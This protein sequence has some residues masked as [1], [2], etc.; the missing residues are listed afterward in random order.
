[1]TSEESAEPENRESEEQTET[2]VMETSEESA[3]SDGRGSEEQPETEVIEISEESP[4]P[5]D[6]KPEGEREAEDTEMP[7]KSTDTVE[8]ESG[9]MQKTETS[10]E[11]SETAAQESEVQLDSDVSN[12]YLEM[13]NQETQSETET[14]SEETELQ[15]LEES[16]TEEPEEKKYTISL[17]END[18]VDVV[19][20]SDT[21]LAGE[22]VLLT[23]S[24]HEDTTVESVIASTVSGEKIS[25][26]TT[27]EASTETP[28][29]FSFEMPEEDVILGVESE[30]V[31]LSEIQLFA[32]GDAKLTSVYFSRDG[33][34][35][36]AA[37][38]SNGGGEDRK[39]VVY[40]YSDGTE[41]R[42]AAYC[43]QNRVHG[44][45]EEGYYNSELYALDSSSGKELRLRKALFYCYG[46]PG[47][48]KTFSGVN[49]KK[50]M[51]TYGLG[52]DSDYYYATHNLVS[53]I[54][55]GKY[56]SYLNTKGISLMKELYGYIDDLPDPSVCMLSKEKLLATQGETGSTRYKAVP[57][58]TATLKLP[59]GITFVNDESGKKHTGTVTM[60]GGTIFHL[61][62]D[63]D[64]K[65]AGKYTLSTKYGTSYEAYAI[66]VSGV[67]DIGFAA[68]S[69]EEGTLS[70]TVSKG[71]AAD[72]VYVVK[73]SDDPDNWIEK[74][75]NYYSLEDTEFTFYEDKEKTEKLGTVSVGSNGKSGKLKIELG[76]AE[77]KTVYYQETARG[78]GHTIDPELHSITL[79]RNHTEPYEI[80]RENHIVYVVI[81]SA[82]VKQDAAGNPLS[83]AQIRVHYY[84]DDSS[85]E[86]EVANWVFETGTDGKMIVS[87]ARKISGPTIAT[88]NG[89][90]VFPRGYYA[91]E[92]IK[93]PAGYCI[94]EDNNVIYKKAT[95]PSKV[96][97]LYTNPK[98]TVSS[99]KMI[100]SNDW[101]IRVRKVSSEP[102]I[103]EDNDRYSLK[104]AVFGFYDE[105]GKLLGTETTDEEGYTPYL[106]LDSID[107]TAESVKI[108]V[109][110]EKA[111]KGFIINST[112]KTVT[113]TKTSPARSVK[114]ADEPIYTEMKIRKVTTEEVPGI[115]LANC[116]FGV[117][118]DESCSN[119]YLVQKM[120]TLS[121]G[122]TD[123]VELDYGTYWL[124][125]LSC[126]EI[127]KINTEIKKLT[128]TKARKEGEIVE[129]QFPNV[130]VTY[131]VSVKKVSAN[132]SVTNGNSCYSFMGA[133]FHVAKDAAM[134]QVI[135]TLEVKDESGMTDSV[136]LTKGTYYIQEAAPAPKGYRINTEIRKVT[137]AK[138]GEV[139]EIADEPFTG[140]TERLLLKKTDYSTNASLA[141]A[142]F[143]VKFY[144]GET[145]TGTPLRTWKLRTVKDEK[146]G[147]YV[148][149][150]S[151]E[152]FISGDDFFTDKDGKIILPLGC[153]TFR[154]TAAPDGFRVNDS[155]LTNYITLEENAAETTGTGRVLYNT[156]TIKEE[157][158]FG[159]VIIDK[160][161]ADSGQQTDGDAVL[162]GAVFSITSLNDFSVSIADQ[163]GRAYDKND[164]VAVIT[165][166][167]DGIAR[168]GAVLQAG[169]YR[170][171]EKTAP[172]GY[173]LSSQTIEF[174]IKNHGEI[175]D[176]TGTPVIDE[177]IRGGFMLQKV[178][179]DTGKD[180][181]QGDADLAGAQ[182]T[183][184]NRSA[185]SVKVNGRV[186]KPGDTV[187]TLTT[188]EKG[189]AQTEKKVLPYGTYEVRETVPP[190]GYQIDMAVKTVTIT[191]E[192]QY[193]K[194]SYTYQ[195]PVIRGGIRVNKYDIEVNAVGGRQGDAA[196]AGAVFTII[197]ESSHPVIVDGKE[198]ANGEV[199][200]ALTTGED[201]TAAT[202]ASALPYGTYRITETKAPYGYLLS[203]ENIAK[204]VQIRENG[205][206]MTDEVKEDVI[207]GGI[208]IAKW[209]QELNRGKAA[210]GAATLAGAEFTLT[211]GSG[212]SVY[213]DADQDGVREVYAPG[214]VIA[215]LAADEDGEVETA[216]D[217]LPC[218]TYHVKE[219]KAPT[220]YTRKGEHLEWDFSIGGKEDDNRKIC[221]RTTADTAV[222]NVPV[223]F[224]IDLF[225]FKDSLTS[226][227][228]T[229]RM[230]PLEG[231]QF[232]I[233]NVNEQ[234]VIVRGKTYQPGEVVMTVTTDEHGFASTNEKNAGNCES[235]ALPYGK[236][237]ISEVNCPEGLTPVKDFIV[238]GTEEGGV[239][240]GK[241]YK[242]LYLN[243]IP[244]E[245]RIRIRKTDAQTGS[246]IP[247][248]ATF[249]ILD[250]EK[251]VMDFLVTYPTTYHVTEFTTNAEGNIETPTK[252]PYGTYYLRE[253]DPPYDREGLRNG[254]VLGED[255]QFQVN[256]NNAWEDVIEVTYTDLPA[257]G[258]ITVTKTDGKTG[259]KISGAVFA[260]FADEDI[261]T[262]DGTLRHK[263]GEQIDVFTV[264]E[265]GEGTSRPL[266]LGAYH[267]QEIKAPKGYCLDTGIYPF[268]LTYDEAHKE[269]EIRHEVL[270][271]SIPNR[272]TVLKLQKKDVDGLVLDGITFEL[273]RIGGESDSGIVNEKA[274]SGGQYVT[275]EGGSIRIPY[276]VSGIYV[277][278]E[279]ETLPGYVLDT[280]LRY[281]AVD[282]N[283]FIYESDQDGKNLDEDNARSDTL[284]L[285][286]INDY[287]KC[288][289]SK[290][291]VTGEKEI[292]GAELEIYDAEGT[293]MYSWTSVEEPHRINKIPAGDYT[294]VEKCAPEGYVMANSVAFTVTE[295]GEVQKTVMI[296]KQILVHKTDL[297]GEKEL[298]G[299]YLTV[300]D[301]DGNVCDSWLSGEEPHPVKGLTVGYTYTLHE[302]ASPAGYVCA[303]D[304]TF[305][306]EDDNSVQ[307]VTMKDDVTK[308][309][310]TKTDL[311]DGTPVIGAE[312]VL[313]DLE[314]NEIERWI[315]EEEPY[316]IEMLPVGKYTLTEI[317]APEGYV[318]AETISFTVQDTGEIQTVNMYDDVTKI[319]IT[320]SDI[321]DG[322]PVIGAELVI[323]DEDSK[324]IER[325]VTD[326]EPHYIEKLPAG[327][328]TLTEI[329]APD[330]YQ[331]A[332][333]VY[334]L[335]ED[336]AE[337]QHVEMFDIP[338]EEETETEETELQETETEE[339]ELRETE[340]E[341]TELRETETEETE[342]RETE[343]EET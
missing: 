216:A 163:P 308:V 28:V 303:S 326:E 339:T 13:I 272:P 189:F 212:A 155:V 20:E 206:V 283:G 328:Y 224:N 243:N 240:D 331:I 136:H 15:C 1:E 29:Q 255:L 94:D 146:S 44:S 254:Y 147:D 69:T 278:K 49:V 242:G 43:L 161:S 230:V 76:T 282:A 262:G 336:T 5:A 122:C 105:N 31:V 141:G 261:V 320:K 341:E 165:T 311:T 116:I 322:T 172:Q 211:N 158:S 65:L 75:S 284:T 203:G 174:T 34:A 213:V 319:E 181:P 248:G 313:R 99:S 177:V 103:T 47:W 228:A 114:F 85:Y 256:E 266:C 51:N 104:G 73:E 263:K 166:G 67:Q 309:E 62:A 152:C 132:P 137:I 126:P 123:S 46:G 302:D 201:G 270:E 108:T 241:T 301:A 227:D 335:V 115:S 287:T 71:E 9:E 299:A 298:P 21:C 41:E 151:R 57:E 169:T 260:V 16:E 285:E 26:I 259:E 78:M 157:P 142:E 95:V 332:E 72:S 276:L 245:S 32:A 325:W 19:L 238:N 23:V 173:K 150:L 296:D 54:Y 100:N 202:S 338:E 87:N 277:V 68:G 292:P 121:D 294:L 253:V 90:E 138:S 178:D 333:T 92:E 80:R 293:L 24:C 265:E 288:E 53:Y 84:G 118:S 220:G 323:K 196:L 22:K 327:K 60:P 185:K 310:I 221:D 111:P 232:T 149:S 156:Q 81:D 280:A 107:D 55:S 120:R 91:F 235:G 124:K 128:L 187:M 153:I 291:D 179:L 222:K 300:T 183:V 286:W 304:I 314:G 83:G 6:Q 25:C 148:L 239:Y 194:L 307:H 329:T 4:E 79:E 176:K 113:L 217:F 205:R 140:T 8:Q 186:Y 61:E 290:V 66:Q 306:V 334:F 64:A 190:K 96:D 251:Q 164:E 36:H 236:Y 269:L 2:E 312:L 175:V 198:Y 229:D 159:G 56:S 315:T 324:E 37:S 274:V 129:V 119:Q 14:Q 86:K 39:T 234:E 162:K 125:E 258:D 204:T 112:P 279:V 295:T 281:V 342:L 17:L 50:I 215:V 233:K 131:P 289:F 45:P 252:L 33:A 38:I 135:A 214:Q 268:T 160:T 7:E 98:I 195:D 218:G 223:H 317:M 97:G 30:T 340:T 89:A 167:D 3:K 134:K 237:E 52:N 145:V 209:D 18:A 247:Q 250:E 273:E 182:F 197:N 10:E 208:R 42:V 133:K 101:R 207:R 297:T 305:T 109:K 271:D 106:K 210:Q 267:V 130:P 88:I 316:Y 244:M 193:D 139:V 184:I 191:E 110:E 77:K 127:F 12:E 48:G 58:N 117:F 226:E 330:G 318:T 27:R 199:V 275:A 102:A 337:I 40:K 82:V 59:T 74:Y 170:I 264:N 93:A 225:K 168:I 321:T 192:G 257:Q 11:S 70:F 63:T 154:E 171:T 249:Q 180:E 35:Y 246:V 188:N 200:A 144:G 231:I 219:I 143:E 343:T